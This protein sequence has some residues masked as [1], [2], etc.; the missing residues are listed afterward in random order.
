MRKI[1]LTLDEFED[2]LRCRGYNSMM[3]EQNFRM[4]LDVGLAGL[5]FSNSSLLFSYILSSLGLPA[6]R[7]ADRIKFEVGRRI[8]EIK[9]DKYYLELTLEN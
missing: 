1:K 6:E 4:F 2:W 8:R 3:G 5:F 7:I 9:A